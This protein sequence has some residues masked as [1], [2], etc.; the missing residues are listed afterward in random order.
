MTK[1]QEERIVK[2]NQK[3][4]VNTGKYIVY[5]MD[6]SLRQRHNS[7]LEYAISLGNQ[8]KKGVVVL[9]CLNTAYRINSRRRAQFVLESLSE[10]NTALINRGVQLVA[11]LGL[12]DTIVPS[13]CDSAAALVMDCAYL[14]EDRII[15]NQIAQKVNCTSVQVE[16]NVVVPVEAVSSHAEYSAKTFR[17]KAT[18]LLDKFLVLPSRSCPTVSS[19]NLDFM[20]LNL[21]R[22]EVII[23]KMNFP[24][25][26][27][28]AG[29]FPGGE[30]E[31]QKQWKRFVRY[32]LARYELHRDASAMASSMMSPY[33]SFGCISPS[34]IL[35]DLRELL[36]DDSAI[37]GNDDQREMIPGNI[38]L[39]QDEI[40]IRRELCI[41]FVWYTNSYDSFE[42][43][44]GWSQRTLEQHAVDQ[45]D[46]YYSFKQL[47]S[48][49]TINVFWNKAQLD[50]VE[51]G[52][53]PPHARMYWGKQPLLW[54]REP[55]E[56]Y[57]YVLKLNDKYELD[58]HSPCG[59]GGVGWC[60][61]L[62]DL[63]F[64]SRP[65]WGYIR[66]MTR[67]GN[68]ISCV[69]EPVGDSTV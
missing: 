17:P 66:S 7:A 47:E 62:H 13:L 25:D 20:K 9:Y 31:A 65:I 5:W 34:E 30:L 68:K 39:Y 64:H 45:R 46:Y 57:D 11:M 41:N 33:L 52:W 50:M 10:L 29:E 54:T 69:P 59:F 48:A 42:G 67:T 27:P 63:P 24:D 14:R 51:H 58:G 19:L 36:Q 23:N 55:S 37:H 12:P 3:P 35:I 32:N 56:A 1:I 49:K 60:Y 61:G 26:I 53:M 40:F 2:L 44:P 22:K 6:A 4:I 18:A 16:D 21:D 38:H 8:I 28:P 15:R 43:L